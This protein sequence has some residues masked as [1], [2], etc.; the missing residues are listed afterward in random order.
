M[1]RGTY[2]A[3]AVGWILSMFY[4][5]VQSGGSAASYFAVGIVG[6]TGCAILFVRDINRGEQK[7]VPRM[8]FFLAAAITAALFFM[9][10]NKAANAGSYVRFL[11]FYIVLFLYFIGAGVFM[12]WKER[13]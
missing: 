2:A 12:W 11:P 1:A 7:P 4:E 9:A 8:I 3:L 6:A 13:R 10:L 5:C